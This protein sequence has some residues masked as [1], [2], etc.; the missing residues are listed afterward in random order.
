MEDR[1]HSAPAQLFHAISIME[2]R[3][4][5]KLNPFDPRE[6]ADL[7]S[8]LEDFPLFAGLEARELET[9]AASMLTASAARGSIVFQEGD[10]GHFLA[11]VLDGKVEIS[12][13]TDH[14]NSRQLGLATPGKTVGEM[15][16][17]DG[18]HRSATCRC[19][20]DSQLALLTA[21]SFQGLVQ[22]TPMLGFKIMARLGKMLSQRLRLT[23]GQL[24][25]HL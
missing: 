15:A 24:V 14:R 6:Q 5:L 9:L 2:F 13:E 3:D 20:N 16:L 17:I 12:K 21:A 1:S 23:T 7:A 10:P 18:E 19:I 8:R 22:K 25:D 11:L 4:D